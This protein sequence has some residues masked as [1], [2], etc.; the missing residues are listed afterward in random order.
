M[1][2]GPEIP[3]RK[4]SCDQILNTAAVLATLNNP[5]A[6]DSRAPAR[7]LR[8]SVAAAGVAPLEKQGELEYRD[9]DDATD[10]WLRVAN[11]VR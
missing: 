10:V 9:E 8:N 5:D 6:P 2:F 1:N 4:Q 11:G 7:K 3:L